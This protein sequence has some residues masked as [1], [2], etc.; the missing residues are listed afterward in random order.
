MSMII[1]GTNGLTFNNATTQASAGQ[2]LQVVSAS[3]TS[4]TTTSSTSFV[5]TGLAATITPKFST[6]KILIL[7]AGG[8][9]RVGSVNNSANV[10]V[11]RG[12]TNLGGVSRGLY[13]A[14]NASQ[15]DFPNSINYYDS[16]STTSATTYTVYIH[17]DSATSSF[18][19]DS[20]PCTLTLLE[21]A[22]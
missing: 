10:T 4:A 3:I 11:Y 16:P 12:A 1:D 14:S 2:V 20:I 19:L 18:G 6:S 9:T 7:L 5:T 22:A 15:T 17:T 13:Q 8:Y 21:I